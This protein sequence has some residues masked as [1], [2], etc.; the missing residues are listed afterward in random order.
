MGKWLVL[1]RSIVVEW[2]ASVSLWRFLW[3]SVV[4]TGSIVVKWQF[5]LVSGLCRPMHLQI[6]K[7]FYLREILFKEFS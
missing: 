3:L 4:S 1:S 2:F 5:S 7:E 6:L